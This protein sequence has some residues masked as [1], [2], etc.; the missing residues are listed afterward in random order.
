MKHTKKVLVIFNCKEGDI[1]W[2]EA[3]IFD[4]P[5]V[6][7]LKDYSEILGKSVSKE[8][9]ESKSGRYEITAMHVVSISYY[10]NN[11]DH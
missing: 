2:N 1:N 7:S 8:F 11:G 5:D 6:M 4:I 9:E 3:D 10:P